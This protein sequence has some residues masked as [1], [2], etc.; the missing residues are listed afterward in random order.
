[1]DSALS[2]PIL[3]GRDD[4]VALADRRL[5]AAAEGRG[6]LLFLAGEA[7]IGKT[8]LLAEIVRRAEGF[9]VI[10]AGASPGDAEVAGGLLGDLASELRLCAAVA[11]VGARVSQRL[12]EFA[13]VM[14]SVSAGCW[15]PT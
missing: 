6:E 11:E 2:S 5:A 9:T 1:V 15:C 3:V 8:R 10:T 14:P 13:D 7:G 4:L 12:R